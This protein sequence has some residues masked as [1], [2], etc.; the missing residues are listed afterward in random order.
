MIQLNENVSLLFSGQDELEEDG[1]T[2]SVEDVEKPTDMDTAISVI[3][4]KDTTGSITG[5]KVGDA[6]LQ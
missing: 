5:S 4:A 3:L 1:E 2:A 6:L